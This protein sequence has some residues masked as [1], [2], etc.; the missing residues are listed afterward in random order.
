MAAISFIPQ[1][2]SNVM[3]GGLDKLYVPVSPK[4][5]I[6][7]QFDHVSGVAAKSGQGGISINKARILNT[8]IDQF[9]SM[10]SFNKDPLLSAAAHATEEQVDAMIKTMQAQVKNAMDTA[11]M[12]SYEL[13]GITPISGQM[14]NVM[15]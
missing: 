10:K 12:P 4:A 1:S 14:F 7:T 3:K 15:A 2:Y 8:L 9:V 11:I 5:V 6:Y 13:A